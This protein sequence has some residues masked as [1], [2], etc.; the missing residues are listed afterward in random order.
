MSWFKKH[1][2]LTLFFAWL[3]ANFL[4]YLG[5]FSAPPNGSITLKWVGLFVLAGILIL[6]TEIWYLLQKRRSLF[7]LFL[8][9]LNWIGFIILLTLENK[10]VEVMKQGV[11]AES[12]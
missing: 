12:Q 8:N 7:F 10:S 3:V 1:L 6:G 4:F 2:N 5:Y 11:A 9:L